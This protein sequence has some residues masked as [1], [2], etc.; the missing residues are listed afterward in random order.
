VQPAAG[1]GSA[2]IPRVGWEVAVS[3][4]EG[5]PDQ[6]IILGSVFNPDRMPD[7][8]PRVTSDP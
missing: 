4:L 5:D 7:D 8:P 6:P 3:F 1:S 2:L